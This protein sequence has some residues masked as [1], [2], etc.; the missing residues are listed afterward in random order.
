MRLFSCLNGMLMTILLGNPSLA[1]TTTVVLR[2]MQE[3]E[4][5]AQ[6]TGLL[7]SLTVGEGETVATGQVLGSLDDRAV[8]LAVDRARLEH[9]Q[10]EAK[11][12]NEVQIKYTQKSLEVAQAE[13]KRSRESIEKF[14]KSISQSQLDVERLAVE[15]IVLQHKQAEHEL[16][17]DRF[18]M[19]LKQNELE[20]A[21]LRLQLHQL[22]A[23]FEGIV[24]LVRG[25]VGEWVEEGEP[26]LRLVAVAKLRA[27]GFMPANQVNLEMVGQT[28]QIEVGSADKRELHPGV[29]RFVSPEIDPVTKQVRV[30]AEVPNSAGQL[31]PG[32]QGVLKVLSE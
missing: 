26:V 3:A 24:V 31:L 13:L 21:R 18:G 1:V 32:E 10:A 5:P 12:N 30:W 25:R 9:S 11:A 28:V 22:R 6:Q 2:P 23:P 15:K 7:R 16:S 14:A 29:L 20:A 4:V 17:L 27:E 19:Q 8:R